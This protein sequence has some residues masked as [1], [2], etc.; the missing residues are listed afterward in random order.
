MVST[1][2]G[3]ELHSSDDGGHGG[4]P[5]SGAGC[6][7]G[8]PEWVPVHNTVDLGG[9]MADIS[10]SGAMYDTLVNIHSGPRVLGQTFTM[11]AAPGTK[12][13]LMDDLTAF[14]AGFG[15]DPNNFAKMDISKGKLYEFSG[16]FRRDRQYFDY[17][18]LG[19][20]SIP[21][22]RA[23]PSTAWSTA[24]RRGALSLAAAL[25]FAGDVQ[26]RAPDDGHQPDNP[27]ASE[28]DV[29]RGVLAEYLSGAD[30][31]SGALGGQVRCVGYGIHAQQYGR[32]HRRD[33]LEAA[34]AHEDDV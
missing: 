22:D 20:A 26:H 29:P 10:G 30:A 34:A 15:G 19:N 1:F 13:G 18:L 5:G 11:H 7:A 24:L 27:A 31:E 17:D 16:M 33:R 25:R 3:L 2:P 32:F 6:A 21:A 23:V 14:S 9:H 12:H 8:D 28:G 4:C